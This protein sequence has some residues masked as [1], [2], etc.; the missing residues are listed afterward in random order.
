MVLSKGEKKELLK[1]SHRGVLCYSLWKPVVYFLKVMYISLTKNKPLWSW[2]ITQEKTYPYTPL[3]QLLKVK[4][5]KWKSPN[6]YQQVHISPTVTPTVIYSHYSVTKR[7][8]LW[9]VY[10]TWQCLQVTMQSWRN[11]T[12]KNAYHMV[13][14]IQKFYK[15][16]VSPND[17]RSLRE[18]RSGVIK[19]MR[20]CLRVKEKLRCWHAK[21]MN[22]RP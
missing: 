17:R 14:F 7:T 11:Q 1:C 3:W 4:N 21:L 12:R 9:M 19:S 6:V 10:T 13:L 20:K 16:Q 15:M 8:K 18:W 5:W 22:W 2:I